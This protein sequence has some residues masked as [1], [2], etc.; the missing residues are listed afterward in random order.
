MSYSL[1]D[2]GVLAFCLTISVLPGLLF[3][4]LPFFSIG[5]VQ[6]FSVRGSG[7]P[8]EMQLGVASGRSQSISPCRIS[9]LHSLS[10]LL[11]R[12]LGY[13]PSDLRKKKI[14]IS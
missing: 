3:G 7:R 11:C 2:V 13:Q 5:K 10:K 6:I 12:V 1:F 9:S 8:V 4:V 14:Y